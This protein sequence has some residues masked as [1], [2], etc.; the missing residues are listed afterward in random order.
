MI[1]LFHRIANRG[2]AQA[3]R[4]VADHGLLGQVRFRN[5]AYPEVEA[6]LVAHGGSAAPALWDGARLIEGQAEVLSALEALRGG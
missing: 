5:L 3:R 2:S 6:D 1:E 4:F